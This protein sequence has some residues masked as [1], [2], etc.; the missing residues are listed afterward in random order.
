MCGGGKGRWLK[1][2]TFA[3]CNPYIPFWCLYDDRTVCVC[4]KFCSGS[5]VFSV[6]KYPFQDTRYDLWPGDPQCERISAT[7]DSS[8]LSISSGGGLMKFSLCSAVS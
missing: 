2:V 6:G 4:F 5:H 3:L 1:N 7:L 8:S